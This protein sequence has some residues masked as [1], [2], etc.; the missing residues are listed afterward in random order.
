[1]QTK[2]KTMILTGAAQGRGSVT[3]V[4][5]AMVVD[6]G[7]SRGASPWYAKEGIRFNA[8][9]SNRGWLYRKTQAN[10]LC[11]VNRFWETPALPW[12]RTWLIDVFGEKGRARDQ[13]Y[14][15][16]PIPSKSREVPDFCSP[17]SRPRRLPLFRRASAGCRGEHHHAPMVGHPGFRSIR[18][19][20]CEYCA[21][22]LV[23]DRNIYGVSE[24]TSLP[25]TFER[26]GAREK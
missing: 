10:S 2:R 13:E 22:S 5:S 16:P 19:P 8:V 9:G 23:A 21:R 20:D 15:G 17:R 24:F 18:Q 4:T 3:C 25:N 12:F 7:R 26:F 11:R 14:Q 1:M 6:S